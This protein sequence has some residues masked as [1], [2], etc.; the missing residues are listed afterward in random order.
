VGEPPARLG[1]IWDPAGKHV[2]AAAIQVMVTRVYSGSQTVSSRAGLQQPNIQSMV[3]SYGRTHTHTQT[4]LSSHALTHS[5]LS[6]VFLSV[7]S[8]HSGPLMHTH[9]PLFR[10][11]IC[12]DYVAIYACIWVARPPSC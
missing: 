7:V 6:S 9:V 12:D 4:N 5:T 10:T 11:G 2:G 1:R 3:I 8:I